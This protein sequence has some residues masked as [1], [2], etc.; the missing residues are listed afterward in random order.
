MRAHELAVTHRP[1]APARVPLVLCSGIGA[2]QELFDPLANALDPDRPLVRFDPPG[3]GA[4]PPARLPYRFSS[5]ARSIAGSVRRLGYDRFD[6]LG[7]SWGGG[8]A[9]QLA[10]QNPYRCRRQILVATGTGMLMVPAHPRTLARMLTPRRHR[11]PAY[12]HRV[13]GE[14][15]GGAARD[16][17]GATIATLHHSRTATGVYGYA[18]QLAAITGWT[19]LPFLPAIRQPTLVL[20]GDDDPLIPTANAAIL[21]HLLPHARIHRYRGGHLHLLTHPRALAPH[22]DTFLNEETTP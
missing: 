6:V 9:Q 18:L 4:S 17:P 1:G 7:I 14:L 11:D 16:D 2:P 12:A 5:L 21:G 13:A 3:I 15:Y 10:F 22:I 8:P 20:A 19:S